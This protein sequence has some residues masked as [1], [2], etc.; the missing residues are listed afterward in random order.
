M[1]LNAH[2]IHCGVF[3]A[4]LLAT[5]FAPFAF[6]AD[7][8]VTYTIDTGSIAVTIVTTIAAVIAYFIRKALNS[9]V[10]YVEQKTQLEFDAQTRA[11]FDTALDNAVHWGTREAAGYVA[12][13][14]PDIE[15]KNK[16]LAD[17]ANYL[18]ERV[19]GAVEH[20]GLTPADLEKMLEARLV[21]KADSAQG[22]A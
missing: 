5:I 4:L 18:L 12:G 22:A 14:V 1:L 13:K 11:Y 21:K 7:D 10:G 16:I 9:V 2:R 19:P 20:F 6:A 17:A 15:T 8:A 3:A